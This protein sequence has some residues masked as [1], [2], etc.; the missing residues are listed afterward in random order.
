[1]RVARQQGNPILHADMDAR[2][3]TNINGPSLIG[4]PAWVDEPLGRYYL[5]FAHHKG[6]YIRLA[7]ADDVGGP[8]TVH[9]PGVLEL[10][11]SH[12]PTQ[13]EPY[14]H[15][16]SPDVHVLD[17]AGE[18]RMYYHGQLEP[19]SQRTRVAVSSDGLNFTA[20]EEVLA[21]PYFRAFRHGDWHYGMAMPGIFYRSDDGLTHF[22]QGPHL[23]E[24]DMRH[25]ALML[26]D[27]ELLVFWTRVGDTPEHVLL[28]R[29]DLRPPWTQWKASE[30]QDVLL[31]ETQWEGATRPLTRS[32]RGAIMEPVNQLRDPCIFEEADKVWLLYCIAGESGI[33]LAELSDIQ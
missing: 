26:R 20:R 15:I 1:M 6:T 16:A 33:A 21:N 10:E 29:I 24:P 7:Y 19:G 4:V 23:F 17:E 9:T 18:I 2:M 11:D 12:F 13:V 14:A 30:P 8:W 22:E 31:P 28:S 5:Y 27:D 25:A 32:V 3:G